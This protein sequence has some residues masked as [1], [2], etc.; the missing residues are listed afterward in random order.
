MLLIGNYIDFSFACSTNRNISLAVT[1][2][3][4]HLLNLECFNVIVY[5]KI[6]N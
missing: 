5:L 4:L 3:Q 2:T 6:K 1:L